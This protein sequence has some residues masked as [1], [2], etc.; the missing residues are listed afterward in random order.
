MMYYVYVIKCLINGKEYV[1]QTRNIKSRFR[2]HFNPPP[3]REKRNLQTIQ[4]AI[5]KHGKENFVFEIYNS[6]KSLD[7]V[8]IAENKLILEKIK[9]GIDLYNMN[10][11]GK[12][13][14]NPTEETRKKMSDAR[15][16]IKLSDETKMILSKKTKEIM[17]SPERKEFQKKRISEWWNSLSEESKKER[18]EILKEGR[19]KRIYKPL[20]EERK[21]RI[22]ETLKKRSELK[23]KAKDNIVDLI[24]N[25]PDCGK[26]VKRKGV[27]GWKCHLKSGRCKSCNVRVG[28]IARERNK[29]IK[30][31]LCGSL[32]SSETR[33]ETEHLD[34]VFESLADSSF[35]C[36]TQSSHT[37][38]LDMIHDLSRTE[39]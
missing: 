30:D 28:H 37:T 25:C 21:K 29:K 6:F 2:S 26:E 39:T 3:S 16:G 22:A 35:L 27:L 10:E 31:D 14:F 17:N 38:S 32:Q 36:D 4:L 12:N 33:F 13:G 19:K 18:R 9:D 20:P 11:G 5:K 8:L 15:I 1:G 23:G 24:H 34:R 7:E